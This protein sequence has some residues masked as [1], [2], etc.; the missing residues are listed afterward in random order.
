MTPPDKSATDLPLSEEQFADDQLRSLDEN[1][2][3]V[4]LKH[5]RQI[6]GQLYVLVK[7]ARIHQSNNVAFQQVLTQYLELLQGLINLTGAVSLEF[8]DN[9]IYCNGYRL[10]SDIV[11]YLSQQWLVEQFQECGISRVLFDRKIDMDGLRALAA[12]FREPPARGANA[13]ASFTGIATI[14]MDTSLGSNN[15]AATQV[16][17]GADIEFD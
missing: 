13:F 5:G 4:I 1:L 17:A 11:G 7:T 2:Q 15:Q 14:A 6:V 12:A 9:D 16:A 3:S 8:T 10:R